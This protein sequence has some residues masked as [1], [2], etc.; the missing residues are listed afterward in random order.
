MTEQDTQQATQQDAPK[1]Q[2][3][4]IECNIGGVFILALIILCSFASCQI[5]KYVELKRIEAGMEAP[6]K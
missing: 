6:A 5:T 2:V 3:T 4:K 1:A